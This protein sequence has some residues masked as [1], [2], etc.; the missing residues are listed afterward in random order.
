MPKIKVT[1]AVVNRWGKRYIAKDWV[2][3][4]AIEDME[5]FDWFAKFE[6]KKITPKKVK[7]EDIKT[8]D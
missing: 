1:Q 2:I 6:T 7:D 4:V 3:E 8:R 5:S